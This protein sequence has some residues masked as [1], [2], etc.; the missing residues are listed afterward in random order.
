MRNLYRFLAIVI[1]L[2]FCIVTM[3]LV[4]DGYV[5]LQVRASSPGNP[6][7]GYLRIWADNA[8]GPVHCKVPST[9]AAC[10]FDSNSSVTV[11]HTLTGGMGYTGGGTLPTTGYTQ[12]E[13][14]FSCTVSGSWYLKTDGTATFDI[15]VGGSSITGGSPPSGTGNTSGSTSGWTTAIT[16]PAELKWNLSSVSGAT[17]ASL[18]FACDQ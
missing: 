14:T 15:L 7:T 2:S 18:S 4:A 16:G 8:A 12:N 6:N 3:A 10:Y 17:F 13:I 9:G 1:L 5:D 11:H